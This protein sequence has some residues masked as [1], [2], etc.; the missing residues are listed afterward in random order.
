MGGGSEGEKEVRGMMKRKGRGRGYRGE[1]E[2]K[3]MHQRYLLQ[4]SKLMY[5]NTTWINMKFNII[6]SG[7]K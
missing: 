5:G 4:F 2:E 6:F 3:E 1:R 7:V